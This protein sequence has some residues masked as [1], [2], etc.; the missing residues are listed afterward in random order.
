[1]RQ[2][3]ITARMS[4]RVGTRDGSLCCGNIAQQNSSRAERLRQP[5]LFAMH[6]RL[7]TGIPDNRS[8]DLKAP[9]EVPQV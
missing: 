6:T 4:E 7:L 5:P 1:M 9:V 3:K 2:N 8:N